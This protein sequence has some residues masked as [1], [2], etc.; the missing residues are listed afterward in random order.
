MTYIP[1]GVWFCCDRCGLQYRIADRRKDWTG[2]VVCKYDADPRPAYLDPPDVY[3]EG[4]P[5]PDAR[6]NPTPYELST[7]E[8]TRDDL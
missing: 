6:P 3:P 5:I 2:L 7:N 8:V 1:G 4:M